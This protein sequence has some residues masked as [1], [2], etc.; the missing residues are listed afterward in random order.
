MIDEIDENAFV[1]VSNINE[2]MGGVF[3]KKSMH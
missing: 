2:V 3:K 1:T